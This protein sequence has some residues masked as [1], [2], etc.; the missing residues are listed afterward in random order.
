M[1][2]E[3]APSSLLYK[4]IGM[5]SAPSLLLYQGGGGGGGSG[6]CGAKGRATSGPP[7][8][9]GTNGAGN[10]TGCCI[11]INPAGPP[12]DASTKAAGVGIDTVDT[13][14]SAGKGDA[15]EVSNCIVTMT[16]NRFTIG[17]VMTSPG[18]VLGAATRR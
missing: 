17:A 5:E 15:A 4:G 6:C 8:G 2:M 7:I 1:K 13:C 14:V 18:G 3:S 9:G 16:V 11:C 12:A 10:R